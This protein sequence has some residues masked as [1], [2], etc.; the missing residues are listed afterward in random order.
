MTGL[1]RIAMADTPRTG[2][3]EIAEAQS[4]KY[5]THNEALRIADALMMPTV[6]SQGDTSPP[7]D[8][9]DGDLY[10]TGTGCSDDWADNDYTFAYYSSTAWI[11]VTLTEGFTFYVQDEDKYYRYLDDSN[12]YEEAFN[13]FDLSDLDETDY[14]GDAGRVLRVSTAEDGV[15]FGDADYDISFWVS[16]QPGAGA[17]VHRQVITR[18]VYWTT[19]LAG[20]YGKAGTASADSDAAVFDIKVNGVDIGDISFDQSDTATFDLGSDNIETLEPGDVVTIEAP[21]PQDS[22]LADVAITLHGR[23]TFVEED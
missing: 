19:D 4:G 14:S 7:S 21:N 13:F 10:A 8:P 20:S 22:A 3:P 6:I 17:E 18:Y 1:E 9:S 12:G 23:R 16:G 5:L 11:F 15:E 2:M